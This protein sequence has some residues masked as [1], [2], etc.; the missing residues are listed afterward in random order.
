MLGKRKR[1]N[2]YPIGVAN[3]CT[4]ENEDGDLDYNELSEAGDDNELSHPDISQEELDELE[5]TAIR[6]E[7]RKSGD[8]QSNVLLQRIAYEKQFVHL[9]KRKGARIYH[10]LWKTGLFCVPVITEAG[11]KALSKR[12][13]KSYWPTPVILQLKLTPPPLVF[14]ITT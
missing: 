2:I 10:V 12:R 7:N 9:E 5:E 14:K 6:D 8:L 4:D 13:G 1:Y 3:E 11:M